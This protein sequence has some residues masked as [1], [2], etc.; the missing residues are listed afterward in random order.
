MTDDALPGPAGPDD[1][2]Q[3]L[4]VLLERAVPRLPVP[5]SRLDKV[6]ERLARRRRRRAAGGAAAAVVSLVAAGALL[7]DAL[8]TDTQ[9]VPPAALPQGLTGPTGVRVSFPAIGGLTLRLPASWDALRLPDGVG[10]KTNTLPDGY[11]AA[12]PL[13]PYEEACS[14]PEK[15]DG[16][17][18][19][20]EP[21]DRLVPG[22]LLLSLWAL[23][24]GRDGAEAL[25]PG[26]PLERA[27]DVPPGCRR[28]G[29]TSYYTTTR[30]TPDAATVLY[31]TL[32]ADGTDPGRRAA[33]VRALLD[34]A[35]YDTATPDTATP[36]QNPTSEGRHP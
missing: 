31:A 12:Q 30:A 25:P 16:S 5:A 2:E 27:R 9:R 10:Q 29:A 24:G 4:R 23:P 17:G 26:T 11:V 36:A 15:S 34:G 22:G 6:R 32:C 21:L 1:D 8:R 14:P 33:E 20:C 13:K 19:L 18:V 3:A 7:P 28:M 35:T